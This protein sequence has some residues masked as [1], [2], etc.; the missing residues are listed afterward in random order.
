MYADKGGLHSIHVGALPRAVA[1]LNQITVASEEMAVEAALAGD[2][3]LVFQ[4]VAYDPLTATM[5]S[6]AEIEADGER[7][8]GAERGVSAAVQ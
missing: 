6:L 8:A 2:P 5:L 3:T 1:P 4:S 7:D